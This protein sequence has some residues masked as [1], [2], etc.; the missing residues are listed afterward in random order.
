MDISYLP[1]KSSFPL[2]FYPMLSATL[3]IIENPVETYFYNENYGLCEWKSE[4]IEIVIGDE[5]YIINLRIREHS[6]KSGINLFKIKNMLQ[7]S[8]EEYA[9]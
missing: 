9:F 5:R 3:E 2:A 7:L 4:P 1:I 6:K 8:K